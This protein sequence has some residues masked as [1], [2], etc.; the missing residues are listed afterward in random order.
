[1]TQQRTNTVGNPAE[2]TED[3]A[4]S[5]L[6]VDGVTKTYGS[7]WALDDV[8]LT[9]EGGIFGLLGANGA[10]KST[11]FQ[12]VLHLLDPDAGS[13]RVCGIDV[14]TDSVAA[15]KMIGYLPEEPQLYARLT[16][17]ELLRFVAGLRELDNADERHELL[18]YFELDGQ[19]DELIGGY[20]LGMRKKIALIAALMGQPRLVL[21]DEPLNG[22]DTEH[23]R[24]LRLRI[25]V[26]AA[27]GST[28]ILSSHVMAF[29]ERICERI[30]ILRRGRLVAE[31]TVVEVREQAD[32]MDAPF[33]DVFLKLALESS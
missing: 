22:L 5:A 10:G 27:G 29:V 13:I 11:L 25:E 6:W 20:S 26:M 2:S 31:G 24:R 3:K 15:R 12:A 28:F 14:R 23:M 8:S 1:M 4:A 16:G 9:V 17:N 21:L 33:E 30:A 7:L 32:L 18:A 19:A